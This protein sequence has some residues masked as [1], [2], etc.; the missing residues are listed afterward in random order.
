MT[1]SQAFEAYRQDIIVFQN[2]S[3]K[4]EENHMICCRAL[5]VFF[6]DVDITSLNFAMVRDWKEELSKRRS[7]ETVRNYI[8]KLRVVLDY[9]IKRGMPV[10][11]PEQI[12]VPKRTDKVP[13]FIAKTDV[14]KL[15]QAVSQRKAG[16]QAENRLRNQAI[17]SM[18]YASG[19]RVTEL[20]NLNRADLQ[21]Q[22]SFTVVGKGGKARLCF[23][24]DRARCYLNAYFQVRHDDNPALFI[25]SQNGL[26]ITAGNVQEIFRGAWKRAG[27]DRPV[28]PHTLRHSFATNLLRNNANIRYVQTLLGHSSLETTQMYTHVVDTDL[29]KA[30]NNFHTI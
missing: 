3:K 27:L 7:A 29:R 1:I 18:L 19:I 15:I 26:R 22:N 28:H 13:H 14:A 30:Y 5:L 24:D 17:I 12:P 23:F 4:T 2:Q 6:G 11:S 8:I 10:L 21:E 9:L 16:Y 25:Q 20:C